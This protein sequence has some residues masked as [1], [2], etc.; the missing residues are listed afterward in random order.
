MPDAS[1]HALHVKQV[2][3]VTSLCEN[4]NLLENNSKML[5][6]PYRIF[7]EL[8]EIV[9]IDPKTNPHTQQVP[10]TVI[11]IVTKASNHFN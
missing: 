7:I 8:Y 10:C 9:Y 5:S 11:T 3:L 2:R 6:I 1:D 4:G